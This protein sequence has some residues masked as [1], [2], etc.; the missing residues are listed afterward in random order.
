MAEH[1]NAE[2]LRKGYAAFSSG[3]LDTVRSIFAEDIAWHVGGKSQLAGDYKGID[4][5]FGFFG[6]LFE[7]SGGN[8][9]MTVHDVIANDEHGVALVHSEAT[10]GDKRLDQ[11]TVHVWHISAGKATEFWGFDWD[12]DQDKA[13]FG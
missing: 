3:D 11:N 6:K 4:D 8:F 1:P 2:L 13:F 7:L 12:S 10:N 5:V 9:T